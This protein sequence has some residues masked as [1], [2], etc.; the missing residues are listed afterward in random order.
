MFSGILLNRWKKTIIKQF[1]FYPEP[2]HKYRCLENVS[3]GNQYVYCVQNPVAF[4]EFGGG[5]VIIYIEVIEYT[6]IKNVC[7]IVF[8]L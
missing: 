2:G 5:A 1:Q 6:F 4:T 3:L 7:T 8:F